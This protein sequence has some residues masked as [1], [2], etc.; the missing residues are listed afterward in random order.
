MGNSKIEMKDNAIIRYEDNA[1]FVENIS[2]WVC[3]T[4][5][6]FYGNLKRAEHNAA[7][8]CANDLPCDCGGR[9]TER[10]YTCCAE[11]RKKHEIE[12]WNKKEYTEWDGESLIYSEALDQ[13]YSGVEEIDEDSFHAKLSLEDM[14]LVICEPDKKP[15]FDIRNLIEDYYDDN[16]E[17]ATSDENL[18]EI[19]TTVND[20]IDNYLKNIWLPGKYRVDLS[21]W[22]K[23]FDGDK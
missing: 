9:N 19:E 15:I 8:C 12:Q 13:Y 1:E 2:G 11:C 3:K 14:R 5:G 10:I 21:K 20:W 18:D 22:E 4:C 7:W 17:C 16:G 23:V 6:C